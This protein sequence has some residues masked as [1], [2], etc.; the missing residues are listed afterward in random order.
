MRSANPAR[1]CAAATDVARLAG[2]PITRSAALTNPWAERRLP[3]CPLVQYGDR[4]AQHGCTRLLQAARM[5]YAA[6]DDP[7]MTRLTTMAAMPASTALACGDASMSMM[8]FD[9]CACS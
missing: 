7:C 2:Y 6:R 9:G 1:K 5:R 4:I 3:H 8:G